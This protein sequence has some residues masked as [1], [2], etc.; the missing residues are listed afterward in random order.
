MVTSAFLYENYQLENNKEKTSK[1]YRDVMQILDKKNNTIIFSN[2]TQDFQNFSNKIQFSKPYPKIEHYYL[3]FFFFSR[4]NFV[5]NKHDKFFN[6]KYEV[7]IEKL[8]ICQEREVAFFI[9]EGYKSFL[10]NYLK[11]YHNT[12]LRYEEF[13]FVDYVKLEQNEVHS[14]PYKI[15]LEPLL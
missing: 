14:K 6:N 12:T 1:A 11:A 9:D 4:Y 15:K 2:W 7:L 8:K 5:K 10:T 3:D 13:D